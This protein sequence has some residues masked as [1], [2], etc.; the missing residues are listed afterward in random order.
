LHNF[1]KNTITSKK[2]QSKTCYTVFVVIYLEIFL[3]NNLIINASL[4]Y[5]TLLFCNRNPSFWRIALVAVLSTATAFLV[6]LLP[7]WALMP[8]RAVLPIIISA[9]AAKHANLGKFL[10]F[11]GVF[12]LFTFIFAG[13][14]F[15]F[16]NLGGQGFA[17][18]TDISTAPFM[19]ILAG[20]LLAG[21]FFTRLARLKLKNKKRDTYSNI[22]VTL[23]FG[24]HQIEASGYLD[25]GNKLYTKYLSPV[26]FLAPE[27]VDMQI[28]EGLKSTQIELSTVNGSTNKTAYR[29][30]NISLA[31]KIFEDAYACVAER[32]FDNFGVLL[33]S[34]MG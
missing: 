20:T 21:T 26:V 9:L 22:S 25:T 23:D 27:L 24:C 34:D 13:C 6:P 7:F 14:I 17:N 29:L 4:T 8:V 12:V 2:S 28:L 15:A 5:W 19:G 30:K 16:L 33:H 31:G 18:Y 1:L 32:A 11:L 3:F 10:S